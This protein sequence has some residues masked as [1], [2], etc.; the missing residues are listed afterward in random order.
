MTRADFFEKPQR[1]TKAKMEIVSSY[2]AAW[3]RIMS[4]KGEVLTYLDLF[5]GRG[6]FIDGT[7]ATPLRIM[8]TIGSIDG[9]E[10]GIRLV[11]YEKKR[12][13]YSVLKE[14]VRKHPIYSRLRFEPGLHNRE[15][16]PHMYSELPF[17]DCTFCFIDPYGN[18][19]ITLGLLNAVIR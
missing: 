7:P 1:H 3:A 14:V 9:L 8:G 6:E 16:S 13:Y 19:G 2:F 12:T 18:K 17:N 15:I 11:F 10:R 5:S 4:V